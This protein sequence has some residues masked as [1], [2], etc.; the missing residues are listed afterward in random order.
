ME[1]LFLII[2]LLFSV[3]IHEVAHGTMANNLGDPTA[4]YE[5]RL[6]LNP[7]KHLDPVG[8][9]LL[10]LMLVIIRSPFLIGWAKPV[11]VNP[12]NLRNPKKDMA[13]IAIAGPAVNFLVA[14]FF[15]LLIQFFVIPER[16]LII[17]TFIIF[18]NILLAV[19]NLLPVPP[20]DG[21][22]ILF[23]FL[24]NRLEYIQ[25]W[26][27]QRSLFL[28]FIFLFLLMSGIIPL[29]QIVDSLVGLII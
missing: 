26:M 17:F 16:F 15:A 24:P 19:F 11:P 4:K 22:K 9:V 5:G 29:F 8:S 14:F 2:I 25:T 3:I 13:K 6:T 12:Y 1:Y 18:I 10:P 23:S 7:L 20:L 28:F 27:E 21:S